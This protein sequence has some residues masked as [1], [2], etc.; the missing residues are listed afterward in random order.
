M[1]V[2]SEIKIE[3]NQTQNTLIIRE[4][5]P[6]QRRN[7]N[8][9]KWQMQ[10]VSKE[11]QQFYYLHQKF[12]EHME[13]KEIRRKNKEEK[14]RGKIFEKYLLPSQNG[15]SFLRDFHTRRF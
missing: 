6:S 13:Q 8:S 10:T 15:S 12:L 5:L 1:C 7:V 3:K 9:L 4:A 11:L 14:G 2:L